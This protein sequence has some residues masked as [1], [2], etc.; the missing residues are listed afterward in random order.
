MGKENLMEDISQEEAEELAAVEA[1]ADSSAQNEEEDVENINDK[2][3]YVIPMSRVYLLDGKKIREVDLSSLEDL[4][5]KDGEHIDR[6]MAK[7]GYH[8]KDKFRDL[9]YTKHIAMRATNLPIEFFNEL[10]WKDM[11]AIS[12]RISVYFLF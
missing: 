5:T 4:S 7:M 11:Q 12:S 10:R 3:P 2:L 6:V 8:P 1:A 9:T